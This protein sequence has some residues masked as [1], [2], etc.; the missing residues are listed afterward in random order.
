MKKIKIAVAKGDGIGPEIMDAT[1]SIIKATGAPL[2]YELVDMGKTWY[3]KGYSS[4]MTPE[5]KNKIEELGILLKG[6]MET[7]K[8]KGMKSINVTARKMWSTYANKRVFKSLNGVDTVFSKAGIPIDITMVRENIEDTYG[9]IEHMLTEDVALCRRFI[10]RPGSMQVHK[11]TF[12]MARKQGA[13]KVTCGHKAN[14]MKMTDGLF[15][16]CFYEVAKDYP[17]IIANDIIVDDLAMKLVARPNDFEVIVLPNLQGDILSDLCAGLVGGLGFAPS[18]NIGDNVCIFEAVHGSAP[19]IAGKNIA[20]PTALLIS[21]CMMLRHLGMTNEAIAIENSLFTTLQQ[22]YHTIDFGSDKE[23]QLNTTEFSEQIIKNLQLTTST[24]VTEHALINNQSKREEY[25]LLHTPT[26]GEVIVNGADFFV[27]STEQP[28]AIAH[29]FKDKLPDNMSLIMISNR[30]TQVYPDGSLLTDCVDQYRVRVEREPGAPSL[31]ADEILD[32]AKE[33]SKSI[34][35][36][37][38]EWLMMY[39]GVKT[40]SL[41]QGQ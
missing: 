4:G 7:P 39:G 30:G 2:E 40:Y 8:G 38:I 32:L 10:T 18:A 41:A 36:C 13:K 21:S 33:I 23:K 31:S 16:E 17:E 26:K 27:E 20:N 37:S 25:Q 34:K 1:L 9:G 19:D 5:A 22:G 15:L 29:K 12:D 28:K 6:P 11:Y 14:I 3:E 24:D 35:I